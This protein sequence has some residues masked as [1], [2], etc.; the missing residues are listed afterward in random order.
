MT[1]DDPY[2]WEGLALDPLFLRAVRRDGALILAG[3][4]PGCGS[5]CEI[6]GAD[7]A[8]GQVSTQHEC[9]YHETKNWLGD[10]AV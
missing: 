2:T 3:R 9:G 5:W 6:D 7:Q 10:H 1:G 4:C 8:R